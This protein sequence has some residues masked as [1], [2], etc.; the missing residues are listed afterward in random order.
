ANPQ[1]LSEF[2]HASSCDPVVVN[3]NYAYVTLRGGN[4]CGAIE[5]QLNVIDISTIENPKLVATCLMEEP[6]GLGI[7][8]SVLF[9]CD[10][11]AGLKIY[12]AANP[13]EIDSHLLA[14]YPDNHAFD[15]IPLGD[16]LVMIGV[17]GLYQY[18]YSDL[19]NIREL[20]HIDIYGNQ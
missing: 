10:G 2:R 18:D 11:N 4:L 20:S 14:S 1:F 15:V 6:Y 13:L 9:V 17:D 8:D 16:V 19:N 3:G 7:D 12:N 5:S